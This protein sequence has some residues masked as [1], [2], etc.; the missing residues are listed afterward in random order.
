MS[1][2]S[3]SPPMG[4]IGTETV[5]F[6]ILGSLQ[7]LSD[8]LS[9]NLCGRLLLSSTLDSVFAQFFGSVIGTTPKT[10]K[11]GLCVFTYFPKRRNALGQGE[12]LHSSKWL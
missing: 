7:C 2:G 5:K 3:L 8:L 12:P 6:G 11:C 9:L 4:P 10:P 1:L